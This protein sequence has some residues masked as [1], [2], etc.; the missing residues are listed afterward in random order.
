VER[1]PIILLVSI[2]LSLFVLVAYWF[3]LRLGSYTSCTGSTSKIR[4]EW[5][6]PLEL[7]LEEGLELPHQEVGDAEGQL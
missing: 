5:V 2:L 7:G 1:N 4:S 3:I 6:A